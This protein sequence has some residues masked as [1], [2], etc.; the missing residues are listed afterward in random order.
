MNLNPG[1]NEADGARAA[2]QVMDALVLK[3]QK[4]HGITK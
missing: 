1:M 4:D 3:A 2:L